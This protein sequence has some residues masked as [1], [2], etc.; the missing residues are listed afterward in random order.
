MICK[1]ITINGETC[2]GCGLCAEACTAVFSQ[3][4]NEAGKS[5]KR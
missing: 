2:S 3:F 5:G 4:S 1:I